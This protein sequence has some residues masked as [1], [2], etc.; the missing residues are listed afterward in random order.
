MDV[1]IMIHMSILGID[2]RQRD[3]CN[4]SKGQKSSLQICS[5]NHRCQTA[6]IDGGFPS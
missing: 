2:L 6:N 4:F 5:S 3:V 1:S